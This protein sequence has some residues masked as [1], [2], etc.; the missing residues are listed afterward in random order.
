M[1]AACSG[2]GGGD[3]TAPGDIGAPP[4]TTPPAQNMPPV[5]S[6]TDL[7]AQ[8][9]GGSI[10]VPINVSDPDGD[11]VELVLIDAPDWVSLNQDG[12]LTG[13]PD[14]DQLGSFDI[15][16]E[17]SDGTN[18]SQITLTL[19]L[20]MD[21]V[22]QALA[23]GDYTFISQSDGDNVDVI[24]LNIID[25]IMAKHRA[26]ITEIFEL[27]PSGQF[28]ETSLA[29]TWRSAETDGQFQ[30]RFYKPEFGHNMPF[31]IASWDS[32]VSSFSTQHNIGIIGHHD[33][34]ARYAV[35][36][37]NPM[38]GD[39]DPELARNRV[40]VNV[41]EWLLKSDVGDDTNIVLRDS[42][43]NTTDITARD[44]LDAISNGAVVYNNFFACSDENFPN[45]ITDETDLIVVFGH[46]GPEEI[47]AEVREEIHQALNNGIS[48]LYVRSSLSLLSAEMNDLLHVENVS[49]SVIFDQVRGEQSVGKAYAYLPSEIATLREAIT[50]IS[51]NDFD[52]DLSDCSGPYSCSE[53]DQANA[54]IENMKNAI[55]RV[56]KEIVDAG[57]DPFETHERNR[58]KRGL[59]LVGDYYRDLIEYPMPKNAT[60]SRDIIRA[61]FGELA[62]VTNRATTPAP[63]NLGS[64]SGTNFEN[65]LRSNQS[66]TLTSEIPFSTSGFYAIPGE[67]ITVTRTDATDADVHIQIQSLNEDNSQPFRTIDGTNYD[68]PAFLTSR[69]REIA[70]GETITINSYNGGPIHIYSQH[71]NREI[72]FEFTN[73]GQHPV[74]RSSAD[75]E[76]FL[77]AL[78]SSDYDWVELLTPSL[79]IL[80]SREKMY[81]T[82]QHPRYLN[83][84]EQLANDLQLYMNDWPLWFEGFQGDAIASNDR[85]ND[86]AIAGSGF[87]ARQQTWRQYLVMD[88]TACE[89]GCI[90]NPYAISWAIAPLEKRE[91]TLVY[92]EFWNYGFPKDSVTDFATR[93]RLIFRG[94]SRD[95]VANMMYSHSNFRHYQA[96]GDL[97]I[98][99]PALPHDALYQLVQEAFR[100]SDPLDFISNEDL[101]GV[102]EH[103]A[104]FVQIMAALEN[105]SV[106]DSGWDLW[107]M[108]NHYERRWSRGSS[109]WGGSAF[110]DGTALGYGGSSLRDE[111]LN[112]D[113]NGWML[114]ALS[115][116]SE[117][118]FTDYLEMWG[119]E[120]PDFA[121]NK[122]ANYGYERIEPVFYA[123][124]PT[125]HCTGLDYPELPIDGVTP[126]PN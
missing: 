61:F 104:L 47:A 126:W 37:A 35:Y 44:W 70:P 50:K 76:A 34:G 111:A 43:D 5:V 56:I 30:N 69:E 24:L 22:E 107:P 14:A 95:S 9:D 98:D 4:P 45:C 33:S 16:I 15:S 91:Q 11:P 49:S 25:E 83:D 86:H 79:G 58:F 113:Y 59:L 67:P 17:A 6:S 3:T 92:N 66:L 57:T 105:Q 87:A 81:E 27:G 85:L 84:P 106:F 51:S 121:L 73:V 110:H 99:C 48:I 68:R 28:L 119:Y 71:N 21:P 2:G 13:R 55:D 1:A 112:S 101:N 64:Y 115:W 118:D 120:F 60:S 77:L 100:S 125:G 109:L 7:R 42:G 19:T 96:S 78:S 97:A 93:R 10:S 117:R 18:T 41:L 103:T 72:S 36:G 63:Q 52:F 29:P 124:P 53:N 75:N 32:S 26:D 122:V 38:Y 20:F 46:L 39:Y 62:T 108:L 8:L 12:Q 40:F 80:A 88:R 123:I 116:I 23:T 31:L 54:F 74:W 82:L 89:E 102:E 90:G 114:V 94:A 65:S